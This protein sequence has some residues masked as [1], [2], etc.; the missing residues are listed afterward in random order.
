VSPDRTPAATGTGPARIAGVSGLVFAALFVAALVLLHRSPSLGATDAD[1]ATFYAR[2]GAQLFVAV[3]LYLVPLAGIAFLWHVTAIRALLDTLDPPPSAMAHGLNLL[4]GVLFVAMVFAGTAAVGAVA[5][6]TSIGGAPVAEP[7]TARALTEVGY[8]L[9]FV[10][11]IRGAGMFA[12]TTTT[13]LRN[14]GVLPRPVAVVGYVLAAFLL[15]SATKN[16]VAVLVFP[17]W[18]VLISVCLLRH[19]RQSAAPAAEAEAEPVP[20]AVA[21]T[22]AEPEA[23]PRHAPTPTRP[24]PRSDPS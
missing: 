12:I 6:G 20:A 4:A 13:L 23:V 5:L 2:D 14:G 18:A 22:V 8:V 10:F 9:V 21:D 7:G 19:R 16:P 1:Y 15:L 17:A 11:A 3:G 24:T